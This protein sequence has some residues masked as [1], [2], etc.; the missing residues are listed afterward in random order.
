MSLSHPP[1]FVWTGNN[2]GE[3]PLRGRYIMG[4]MYLSNKNILIDKCKPSLDGLKFT[5]SV[6]LRALTCYNI[7]P[8]IE[9]HGSL[10]S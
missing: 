6:S 7:K 8:L 2:R 3:Q 9:T 1:K 4:S 5:I 10:K